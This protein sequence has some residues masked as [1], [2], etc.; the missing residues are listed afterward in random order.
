MHIDALCDRIRETAYAIHVYHGPGHLE[1]IYE[2]ALVHRLSKCGIEFERQLSLPVCD[3]DGAPLG[4]YVADLLVAK[5][6]LVELK[7]VKRILPEHSAQLL[8][9]LKSSGLR[10]GLLINF[11]GETFQIRRF[12]ADVFSRAIRPA[13]F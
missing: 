3:E 12:G 5:Q 10:F 9:Y 13:F 11:G 4:S 6:V 1:R 2:N 8:G 7:A